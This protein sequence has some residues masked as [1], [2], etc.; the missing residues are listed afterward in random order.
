MH[1]SSFE[2]MKNFKDKY[3]DKSS[4]L[5]ILDVGS[6]DS[7]GTSYNYGSFLNEENWEYF[8][9]DIR[10]GPNVDIIVSIYFSFY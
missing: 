2:S 9:M 8:G 7:S 1:K 4:H 5:K 10:E 3:L 6:Y